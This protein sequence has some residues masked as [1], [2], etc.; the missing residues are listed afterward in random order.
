MS[1]LLVAWAPYDIKGAEE[2][3]YSH[4]KDGKHTECGW[5]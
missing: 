2:L 1:L 4:L 3:G 5:S